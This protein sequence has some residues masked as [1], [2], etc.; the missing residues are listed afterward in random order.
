M[1]FALTNYKDGK[2][3]RWSTGYKGAVTKS[4]HAVFLT[5]ILLLIDTK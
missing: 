2:D 1:H 4:L 5:I 3:K